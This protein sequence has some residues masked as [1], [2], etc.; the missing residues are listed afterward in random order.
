MNLAVSLIFSNINGSR[1][2]KKEK[3]TDFGVLSH[4]VGDRSEIS[5]FLREDI[6]RMSNINFIKVDN[7]L[8]GIE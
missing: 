6:E 3:H 5:N 2:R 1:G 4:R 8:S 7:Q